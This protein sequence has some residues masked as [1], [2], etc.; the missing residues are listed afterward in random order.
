MVA[1]TTSSICQT[2]AD[3]QNE[4]IWLLLGDVAEILDDGLDVE[5]VSWLAPVLEV[6][7]QTMSLKQTHETGYLNEVLI[8]FPYWSR[9]V[10]QLRLERAGL[11][12]S[13]EDL[14]ARIRWS[15]PLQMLADR[16]QVQLRN[17][18][19]RMTLH[20]FRERELVQ[21]VWYNEIGAGD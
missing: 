11:G 4:L 7:V 20:R 21:A 13:L 9:Q 19:Y 18:L 5:N 16:L 17:W 15:L 10:D 12:R 6:L 14:L 8:E 3:S 1:G 2:E